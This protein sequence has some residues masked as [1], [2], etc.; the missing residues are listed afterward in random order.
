V[1]TKSPA[2]RTARN[3]PAKSSQLPLILGGL[4]VVALAVVIAVLTASGREEA[5]SVADLAGNP[6]ID[7]EDLPAFGGD[8]A[9]DPA[10]GQRAPV[11]TGADFE[12]TTTAVGESGRPQL[13]LFLA[14]WCPACQAELPEVVTWLEEGNLPDGVELTAIAT[15]LDSGRPN[16]PPDAWYEREGYDGPL[17][18][19][20]AD[21]S[22]AQAYGLS[23]TPYWVALDA[24]GQVAARV[25]GMI[26]MPQLSLL[27]DGLAQG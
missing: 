7:G 2:R 24:D 5:V 17:L 9:N 21:G 25:S 18:V 15:G 11:V 19:D 26:D 3:G 12:G 13:L 10:V 23:G 22:I 8:T 1:A 14:S 20:D 6:V 4:A 27:A 16:W